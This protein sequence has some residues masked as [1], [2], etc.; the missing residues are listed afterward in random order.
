MTEI[1]GV[2]SGASNEG[3]CISSATTGHGTRTTFPMSG[4][5]TEWGMGK[6]HVLS[7]PYTALLAFFQLVAER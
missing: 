3:G 2:Y 6:G 1:M 7:T 5:G 4:C